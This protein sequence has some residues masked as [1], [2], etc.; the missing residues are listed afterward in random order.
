M[1]D[2]KSL[3]EKYSA[4]N[5]HLK[6]YFD[7]LFANSPVTSAQG[8]L[9]DYLF[10]NQS[11]DVFQKDLEEYLEIKSSSVTSIL[12]NLEKNG[13]V[14]R[15]SVEYDGRLKK[16]SMTD[17]AREIEKDIAR[18]VSEYMHSLFRDIPERDREGFYFVMCRMIENAQ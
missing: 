6:R 8:L 16:I 17:K 3:V 13:Y 12:D 5:R 9:L 11:R 1:L 15:E 18:R 2:E 10:H 7:G 4:M 14:R